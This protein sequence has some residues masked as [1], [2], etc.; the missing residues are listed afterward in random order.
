M[1]F[2]FG[3]STIATVV[4]A[5]RDLATDQSLEVQ[6]MA[7]YTHARIGFEQALGRTL[8][9][10]NI[11]IEEAKKGQVARQSVI[12]QDAP[13]PKNNDAPAPKNNDAPA[14]KQ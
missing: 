4:Q 11:S 7:N 8:D 13:A 5:E 9:I 1:R 3:E 2:K 10:N 12:P 6:S 14:P